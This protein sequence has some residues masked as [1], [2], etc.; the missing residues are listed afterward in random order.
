MFAMVIV[1][2]AAIGLGQAILF[3]GQR[4]REASIIVGSVLCVTSLAMLVVYCHVA[5][6]S[7]AGPTLLLAIV[8]APVAGSVLGYAFG[9]LIGVVFLFAAWLRN[10]R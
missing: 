7:E 8:A 4:P 2:L 9:G 10:L 1:L 3:R 6:T 5:G